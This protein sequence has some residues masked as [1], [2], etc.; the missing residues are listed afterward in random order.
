VTQ[1]AIERAGSGEPAFPAL[2]PRQLVIASEAIHSRGVAPDR[3]VAL[4]LA[5][6]TLTYAAAC[7]FGGNRP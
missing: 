6:T 5:M 3:F 7:F 4:L 2:W 1:Q